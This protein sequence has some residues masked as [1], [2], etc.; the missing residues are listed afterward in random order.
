MFPGVTLTK[1][2]APGVPSVPRGVA[3]TAVDLGPAPNE[4]DA[5]TEQEY[6]TP[7]DNSETA[8]GLDDPVA[9][10]VVAPAVQNA[11]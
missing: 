3:D 11:E 4:F 6:V 9:D 10:T 5:D 8:R 7:L 2:G 1:V